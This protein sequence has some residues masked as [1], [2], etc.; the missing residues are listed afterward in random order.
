M[1][2]ARARA[3]VQRGTRATPWPAATRAMIEVIWRPDAPGKFAIG[4]GL[5]DRDLAGGLVDAALEEADVALIQSDVAQIE[6]LARQ[7]AE[8]LGDRLLDQRR[9]AGEPAIKQ[10]LKRRR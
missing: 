4:H 8:D 9:A 7:Q 1:T 3:A 6:M 2:P 10:D 5:A